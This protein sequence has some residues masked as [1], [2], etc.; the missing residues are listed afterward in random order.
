MGVTIE[1]RFEITG[2]DKAVANLG[3]LQEAIPEAVARGMYAWAA[4]FVIPQAQEETPVRTG[5]LRAS[6]FVDE[7]TVTMGNA[8]V[9]FGFS[10][11]YAIYVHENLEAHHDVG[12]AK[13]LEDPVMR[14]GQKAAEYVA[15]EIR[16]VIQEVAA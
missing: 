1:M 14:S 16:K 11:N 3:K 7:P 4:F 6:A 10:A 5:Y 9:R 8:E 13:F 15:D 2:I 12:K